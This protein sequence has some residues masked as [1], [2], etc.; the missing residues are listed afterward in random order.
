MGIETPAYIIGALTAGG[1]TFGYVKTGSIPSVAA[2]LTVG[3]LY[4][5]G[6]YRI[7]NR[8]SY[9]VELALLASIILAGSSIPRALRSQK[10]L[11]AGLSAL[12]LYGL[13]T[14]GTAWNS[15]RY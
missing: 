5:L 8:Q 14:F 4:L 3:T 15:K 12:A 11:P 10:P 6:G 7:Q 2:G 13:Y 1:G 9:G